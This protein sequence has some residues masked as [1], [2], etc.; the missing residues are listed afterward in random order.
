MA[1]PS[2]KDLFRVKAKEEGYPARSVYKLKEIQEKYTLIRPGQRI[3]DLGCH[4]GSW[5]KFCSQTVGPEGLVLGLDLKNPTIPMSPNIAF[6]KTD[7]LTVPEEQIKKWAGE[8]DLV[9]SDLSPKTSGIKWLDH[10]RSLDLNNRALDLGFLILKK[11]GATVLKIFEGQG[12]K[13]F[14]KKMKTRFEQVQIHKPRSSRQ[15][16]PEIYLI[17]RGFKR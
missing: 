16:S 5:L 14:I 12:S 7:L 1:H 15:E 10:Q 9:L 11:G 2:K 6:L 4:P 17:G 13:D 8:V 3:V